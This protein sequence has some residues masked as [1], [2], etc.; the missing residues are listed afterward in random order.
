MTGVPVS[1]GAYVLSESTIPGYAASAWSCVGGSFAGAT[2]TLALGESA[3]CTITNDDIPA[4]L[5]L[6][7]QVVNDDG[8]TALATDWTLSAAGP[9]P[10][11]TGPTGDPAVTAAPVSAGSYVLS[12]STIPGYVASPWSC[13][14]G[15]ASGSTVTLALG[16]SATCT[17]TNDDVP[18]SLTLVKQVVNDDGGTAVADG[19]DVDRGRSDAGRVGTSGDAGGDGCAGEC[20]SLCAVGVGPVGYAAS[21]W[22]CVGGTQTGARSHSPSVD[23]RRARSSTM[24]L[25]RR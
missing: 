22:S 5:T 18:A 10:G 20:G 2:V 21:A 24:T 9:T 17:I 23:R 8:G 7:K 1:A 19:L 13:V 11:V 12:E 25:R 15:T 6:V 16:E 14:G 4:S 3:T